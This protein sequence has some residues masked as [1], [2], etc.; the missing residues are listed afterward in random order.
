MLVVSMKNNLI[1]AAGYGLTIL[2]LDHVRFILGSC[3]DQGLIV[4]VLQITFQLFLENIFEFL[5]YYFFWRAQ[6][7]VIL[8]DKFVYSA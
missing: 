8:E 4:A 6:Y 7:L 3:S 2:F 5:E 1:C